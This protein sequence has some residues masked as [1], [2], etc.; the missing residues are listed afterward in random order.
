MV[1]K[2]LL[3][4]SLLFITASCQFTE[5][6]VLNPDGSGTIS[7]E[8]NMNEMMAFAGSMGDSAI[9]KVDTTIYIKEYL[10]ERKDSI[11]KLSE[12]DQQ[13]GQPNI[14]LIRHLR[15]TLVAPPDNGE[16]DPVIRFGLARMRLVGAPWLDRVD[17]PIAGI[18]GSTGQPRGSVSVS[19]ISTENIELGY[20][21]PPGLGNSVNEVGQGPGS[22]GVQV[23][24][25]SLRVVATDLRA[26]ERAE[27]YHRFTS[28]SQNLLAYREMRIWVRGRGEGWEDQRLNAFF[29]VGTDADNFYYYQA[30]ASTLTWQPEMVVDLERWRE[31]RAE[32]ETR[33][34]R[35][36][37]PGGAAECGGDPEAYVACSSDG[38]VVHLLQPGISP[39]NLAAVQ[40]VATGIIYVREGA[41]ILE[42]ELW[43][44]DIRL[45]RPISEVGVAMAVSTRLSAG[46]LGAFDLSFVSQ[47]GQFRQIGQTPSYRSTK[48]FRSGASLNL[49]RLWPG[50]GLAAP[51]I[52][53]TQHSSVDPELITG[54]DVRGSALAGLRRP[55]TS[56]TSFSLNARR[57]KADGGFLVKALVNPL[58]V[59]G[60]WSR[61]SAVTEYSEAGNQSWT[62]QLAWSR[63]FRPFQVPIGLGRVV[64]RLPD[65]LAN[66]AGGRGIS[67]GRLTVVP[68]QLRLASTLSRTA[69]EATAFTV[70]IERPS[71]TLLI[72]NRS[73]QHLWRNSAA[74]AWQPLGMLALGTSWQS[75]RDLRHYPDSTSIGR[76]AGESRKSFLGI[77]AGVERDR[78]LTSSINVTPQLASWLRP[79]F[80]TSSNF[81]L[82]RNL[83]SRNPV[84][85]DGD[86]AGA[87]ILPQ[88]LNNS[89]VNEMGFSLDPAVLL[90]RIFGDTSAT[91]RYFTRVRPIDASF[92]RTF[93]STFDLASFDPGAGYQFALGGLDQFLS[94]QGVQAVGA[95]EIHT[96]VVTGGL[97][98]PLGLSAELSLRQTLSDRYQRT[99]GDQ[100]LLASTET[101]DWP[102][103]R[104]EWTRSSSGGPLRLLTLSTGIRNRS[105][106]STSPSTAEGQLPAITTQESRTLSPQVR[107]VFQNGLA[108]FASS[109]FD[110]GEGLNNG[111]VRKRSND[112]VS[113]NVSWSVRLPAA[114]SSLRKPLRTSLNARVMRQSECM[115]DDSEEG[116]VT[117]SDFRS[118]DLSASL[119]TDVVGDVRGSLVVQYVLNELRQLDR[120][121][122]AL[123]LSLILEVPL[124]ILEGF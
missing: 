83:T 121:T 48:T 94:Q 56:V 11:Y 47:D 118:T 34:L 4:F 46:E 99:S 3:F 74:V 90:R 21:S 95:G 2:L 66:S 69:G 86:T 9:V 1:P 71:D 115:I 29:K 25:K 10:N 89:R 61:S 5:T 106:R 84:Q 19:S 40:E 51:F 38:Y 85:V 68:A 104:V 32:I 75:T 24:E 67:S 45:S 14:R 59:S 105:S 78:L 80:S 124:T 116:C 113:G 53:A 63:T 97:D 81:V 109:S 100:F 49:G 108:L 44:D 50:L 31:L 8:L 92:S 64:R 70:P 107:L 117:I 112:V 17:R 93:T 6:L 60:N 91:G 114:V 35:G 30:P 52:M 12:A 54:S 96:K 73:L 57:I 82:S 65:W 58:S 88:T 102:D 87:Y 23:N 103:G 41:P 111:T 36:E 33:F 72:P 55:S 110:R 15:I 42:T 39:A 120:K 76:L 13:I 20:V 27:A 43:I 37:G 79:R 26:E 7:V 28:G 62:T 119:E 77:D 98:L 123:N 101:T 18:A 122:A 22:L 16:A